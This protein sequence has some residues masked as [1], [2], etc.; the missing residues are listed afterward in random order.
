MARRRQAGLGQLLAFSVT[1]FAMAMIVLVRGDLLSTWQDQL[2][3][4]TPNY[5]AINIQPSER[6]PFEA[7][8]SPRVETQ[9]TLYRWCVGE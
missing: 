1:F 4:N 9:S 2:P 6:D 8:V 7:A 3:E 5:F